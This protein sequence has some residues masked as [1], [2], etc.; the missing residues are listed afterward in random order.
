MSS[1]GQRLVQGERDRLLKV[2]YLEVIKFVGSSADIE[3]GNPESKLNI[4]S[5]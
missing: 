1:K 2:S 3:V 5:L 4:E